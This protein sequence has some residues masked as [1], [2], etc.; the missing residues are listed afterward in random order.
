MSH[1]IDPTSQKTLIALQPQ[2]P[3]Y[4][5]MSCGFIVKP[6]NGNFFEFV[7]SGFFVSLRSS[8]LQTFGQKIRHR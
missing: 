5:M 4:L 3:S 1:L 2:L 6:E 8:A 7:D